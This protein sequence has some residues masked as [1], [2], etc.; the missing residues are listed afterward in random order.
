MNSGRWWRAS[1]TMSMVGALAV[2]TGAS[3]PPAEA[4]V[5]ASSEVA[6]AAKSG[7]AEPGPATAPNPAAEPSVLQENRLDAR[8]LDLLIYSPALG[9]SAPVRLL[10]PRG[11]KKHPDRTWPV[12]YLLHGCCEDADYR[13]WTNFTDVQRFMS[14]KDVLTV[15]PSGGPAGFYT[16]WAGGEPD[17]ESFHLSELRGILER[18]YGAGDRRAVAGLSVGGYGSF[19]YA[20]RHPGMFR[21]AASYSGLLN[22]LQPG[23]PGV[24]QGLLVREG[25]D[26]LAMWGSAVLDHPT[27]SARNPF[28]HA[29]QLRGTALYVSCGNGLPGPLDAPGAL[30]DSL[31]PSALSTSLAMTSRLK[32]MGIAVTEHYYGAG[33]HDWPYWERELHRSWP[34]FADRLGLAGASANAVA[35]APSS[36]NPA[37]NRIPAE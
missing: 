23:V 15:I 10:L 32:A 21:A 8:T 18:D 17:W 9:T 37:A 13:A 1:L 27:W 4:V 28:D 3:T 16:R 26:P 12:L 25:E 20:F 5:G 24:V 29:E 34:M 33:R 31:E 35:N 11:W 6:G 22:T 14:D 2:S 7:A 36:T 19:A 30:P